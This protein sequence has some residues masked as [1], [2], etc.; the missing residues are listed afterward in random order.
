MKSINDL[1]CYSVK[2]FGMRYFDHANG[3]IDG[4]EFSKC[5]DG[6][7][8]SL[9]DALRVVFSES[10]KPDH[11]FGKT[12]DC[13][14]HYVIYRDSV[15]VSVFEKFEDSNISLMDDYSFL[16]SSY[17]NIPELRVP[18][19]LDVELYDLVKSV[20][21][22]SSVFSFRKDI[23]SGQYSKVA[24]LSNLE[25]D[26]HVV[27]AKIQL[28]IQVDAMNVLNDLSIRLSL[29]ND[30]I[31]DESALNELSLMVSELEMKA[32]SIAV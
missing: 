4:I 18:D 12:V 24:L 32:F 27:K 1:G 23:L 5:I 3:K 17:R 2:S 15:V 8:I 21:N 20:V 31:S 25:G 16:Y 22:E 26:A 28:G 19:F 9:N 6:T 13:V 14:K 29:L 30:F 10:I 11:T 7:L